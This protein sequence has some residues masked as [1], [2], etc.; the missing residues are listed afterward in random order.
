M[1][2]DVDEKI[3]YDTFSAFGGIASNP[4]VYNL[5]LV[6]FQSVYY[7][8]FGNRTAD[9]PNFSFQIMR[10]PDT[11]NSRGFG[12]I[13]YDSFDASDAAIE[14]ILFSLL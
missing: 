7:Y 10:D 3:L 1:L 12:F 11:G 6:K 8:L 2:Q 4:K 5:L 13:S 14:V 9:A